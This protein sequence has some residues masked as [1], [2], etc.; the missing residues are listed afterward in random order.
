MNRLVSWPLAGGIVLL[1]LFLRSQANRPNAMMPLSIFRIPRFLAANLLT[2]L[3]YGALGGSLYVIPF[4]LIQVRYYLPAPDLPFPGLTPGTGISC[5]CCPGP[6]SGLRHDALRPAAHLCG[7]VFGCGESDRHRFGG[8]QRTFPASRAG[9][10]IPARPAA[11]SRIRSQSE[12]PACPFRLAGRGAD[13]V[14]E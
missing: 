8:K 3:L 9:G 13:S 10:C 5:L 11:G 1:A 2:F 14:S 12:R 6:Y 7:H 4:Y